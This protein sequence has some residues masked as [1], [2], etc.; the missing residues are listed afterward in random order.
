MVLEDMNSKQGISA[1]HKWKNIHGIRTLDYLL[2]PII[3]VTTHFCIIIVSC[4]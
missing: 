3:T 4:I 2:P 1:S